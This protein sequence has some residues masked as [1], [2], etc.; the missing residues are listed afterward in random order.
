MVL[1]EIQWH[2]SGIA[3][4]TPYVV[5]M[6]KEEVENRG[7]ARRQGHG[8]QGGA[9]GREQRRCKAEAVREAYVGLD[10]ARNAVSA[11][12]SACA[13]ANELVTGL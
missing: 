9:G 8:H 6:E 5:Q 2:E 7:H 3:E 10:A 1:A 12:E 13:T 11:A 4:E